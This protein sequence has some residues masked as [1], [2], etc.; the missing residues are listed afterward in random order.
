[1]KLKRIACLA[2]ILL[3]WV[4][5]SELARPSLMQ[6]SPQGTFGITDT[7]AAF[8]VD[9]GAGLVFQVNKSNGDIT[10]IVFNG[11]EYIATS[12][13]FAQISS[14]LGTATVTPETDGSTFVKL[15]L[16]TG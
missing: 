9:T 14:G 4:A 15:A 2:S 16:Q 7:G 6:Q 10:S 8:V 12:G 1:M 13:K 5:A 3:V 11:V